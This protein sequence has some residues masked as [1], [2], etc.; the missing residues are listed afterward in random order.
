M[1]ERQSTRRMEH[2]KEP[3]LCMAT[4]HQWHSSTMKA[5]LLW[6]GNGGHGVAACFANQC[7]L[8]MSKKCFT[9]G[10]VRHWHGLPG[11]AVDAPSLQ[12]AK[13]RLEGL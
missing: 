9:I 5:P 8:D 1:Q 4:M 11:E 10:A 12:I 7:R 6:W 13:V 3:R 2:P